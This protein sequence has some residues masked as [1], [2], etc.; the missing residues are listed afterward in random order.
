[1]PFK[2]ALIAADQSALEAKYVYSENPETTAAGVKGNHSRRQ[3]G[4][5][6]SISLKKST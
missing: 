5:A 2:I 1:M 4:M 3:A 6:I